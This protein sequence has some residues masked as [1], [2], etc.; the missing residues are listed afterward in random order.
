M[1]YREP[2]LVK[3]RPAHHPIKGADFINVR[4]LLLN[5][6]YELN[7]EMRAKGQV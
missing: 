2:G 4:V 1:R 6:Q 3:E 7:K 5:L